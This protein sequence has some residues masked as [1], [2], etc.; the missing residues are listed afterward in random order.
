MRKPKKLKKTFH[1]I[2]LGVSNLV[3]RA[4]FAGRQLHCKL[5]ATE[6]ILKKK[7]PTLLLL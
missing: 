7:Y 4:G 5:E 2:E 6:P 1:T 3:L